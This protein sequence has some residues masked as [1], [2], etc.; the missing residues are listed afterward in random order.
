MGDE[1]RISVQALNLVAILGPKRRRQF[2]VARAEVDDEPA[3]DPGFIE[4]LPGLLGRIGQ[5]P[6]GQGEKEGET[7]PR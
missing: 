3:G 2:S 4:D 6:Q 1:G 5:E 7:P